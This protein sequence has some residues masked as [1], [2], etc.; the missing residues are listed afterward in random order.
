MNMKTYL[1]IVEGPEVYYLANNVVYGGIS[2][3]VH[4]DGG[5]RQQRKEK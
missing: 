5:Q 3:L 4:D 2:C 1:A